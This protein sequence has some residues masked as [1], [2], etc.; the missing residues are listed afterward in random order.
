MPAIIISKDKKAVLLL[1][2][3]DKGQF[4]MLDP[5][6]KEEKNVKIADIAAVYSGYCIYIKPDDKAMMRHPLK[7][8]GSGAIFWREG[9]LCAG[10]FGILLINIFA[11][12]SLS[13]P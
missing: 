5:V 9:D 1:A 11:L 10:C 4:R 2:H 8:T 6:T 13:S 12:T 7:T 3:D